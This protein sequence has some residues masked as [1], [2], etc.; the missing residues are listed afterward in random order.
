MG[1]QGRPPLGGFPVLKEAEEG[2]S[3]DSEGTSGHQAVPRL[4][5]APISMASVPRAGLRVTEA[6]TSWSKHKLVL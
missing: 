3:D 5:R 6:V 4:F 1:V 2:S